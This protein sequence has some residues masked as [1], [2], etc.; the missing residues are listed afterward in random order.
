MKLENI[1]FAGALVA[2][3]FGCQNDDAVR[4]KLDEIASKLDTIDQRLQAV[5][6]RP[7][8][9]AAAQRPRGPQPGKVYAVPVHPE[10]GVRGAA[11]AKV[12]I[13]EAYEYAC[14]ACL[15]SVPGL[16]AVLKEH[17]DDDVRVVSKSFVVHPDRATHAAL[18]ACAA[19]KQGKFAAY[20][21]AL[22]ERAWTVDGKRGLN[23]EALSVDGLVKLAGE[24]GMDARQFRADLEGPTCA[25]ALD[26]NRK[27]LSAIGLR[28][29][30]TFW[31][32]G[33]VYNGPRT[34]EGFTAAIEEE[35]K[36]ADAAIAKGVKPAD[37]YD[38]LVKGG[39]RTM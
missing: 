20:D 32:N 16:E 31:I 4:G 11:S 29:T 18:G 34:L 6:R 9:P 21:A 38:T 25:A 24:L 10:D 12:T 1:V 3:A 33:K 5:E 15:S 2:L 19:Q 17:G 28:G 27:E 36:A 35:R 8:G 23:M 39:S 26:R 14:P 22:F 13:V 30:P 7:A 37:Y